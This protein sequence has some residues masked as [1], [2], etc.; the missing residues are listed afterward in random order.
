MIEATYSIR[1]RGPTPRGMRKAFNQASKPA[2]HTTGVHFH[3][4]MADDRFTQRHAVA[5]GYAPRKKRYNFRKFKAKGHTRPLE[6]SGEARRA[7]KAATISSTSGMVRVRYPGTR[8]F[9]FRHPK[10]EVNM[11]KE[12]TTVLPGEANELA[13]VYDRDLDGRLK[14]SNESNQ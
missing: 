7:A 8:V 2:W 11:V 12:F 3:T 4:T 6:Y 14:Q 10:S 13:A 1:D 5:A 9:N